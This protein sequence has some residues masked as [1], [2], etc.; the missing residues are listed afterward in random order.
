MKTLLPQAEIDSSASTTGAGGD[1]GRD[2]K[3]K[4]RRKAGKE[5]LREP[6][7]IADNDVSSLLAEDGPCG[8]I[9]VDSQRPLMDEKEEDFFLSHVSKSDAR[10][11][12]PSMLKTTGGVIAPPRPAK[13]AEVTG[14]GGSLEQTPLDL[15]SSE[16][17]SSRHSTPVKNDIAAGP[18]TPSPPCT[19]FKMSDK[20]I[21]ID[22]Q[23]DHPPLSKKARISCECARAAV[24]TLRSPRRRNLAKTICCHCNDRDCISRTDL[25][26]SP[27]KTSNAP[28]TLTLNN[29]HRTYIVNPINARPYNRNGRDR[30]SQEEDWEESDRS[31]SPSVLPLTPGKEEVESIL[32]RKNL[33]LL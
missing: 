27:Q 3:M 19:S 31:R 13:N 23:K 7:E 12:L 17:N 20:V 16:E 26:L 6:L 2:F 30:D 32:H 5:D 8:G 33:T 18:A 11:L 29:D 21:E 4:K 28:E 9:L 22:S 24:V 25:T 1:D 15:D 10:F 14:V